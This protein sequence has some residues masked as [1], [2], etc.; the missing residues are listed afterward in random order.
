MTRYALLIVAVALAASCSRAPDEEALVGTLEA[1][2][3]AV[4]EGEVGRFMQ[5]VADDFGT[6]DGAMDR[7]A[8]QRFAI[9]HSRLNRNITVVTTGREIEIEGDRATVTLTALVTG[10]NRR[11]I[12]ERGRTY[13]VRAGL[14]RTRS[15]WELIS[16]HWEPGLGR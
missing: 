3:E 4:E 1:M 2:E 14:R 5:Y 6:Q 7:A 8:L 13:A 11:L 10:G 15:D 16:A 12:P 9:G